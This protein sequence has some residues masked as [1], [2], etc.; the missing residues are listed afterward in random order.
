MKQTGAAFTKPI[1]L[2]DGRC[3]ML[4][5]PTGRDM[6]TAS[7]QKTAV[8]QSYMLISLLTL[9]DPAN[10]WVSLTYED[11]MDLPLDDIELLAAA[12]MAAKKK[13]DFSQE[14]YELKQLAE[15]EEES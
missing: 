6:A 9:E 5:R 1:K 11:I 10:K 8:Q 3:V 2:S 14:E 4:R 12:M 7:K 15:S 13:E